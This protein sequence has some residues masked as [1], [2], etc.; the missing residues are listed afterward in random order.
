MQ[1]TEM[2]QGQPAVSNIHIAFC[3]FLL[4]REMAGVASSVGVSWELLVD[5][6][7]HPKYPGPPKTLHLETRNPKPK[8]MYP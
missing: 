3:W 8:T 1:I 6:T 7:P 4:F 5:E 2:L